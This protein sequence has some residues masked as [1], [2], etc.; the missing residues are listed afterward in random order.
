MKKNILVIMLL[1]ASCTQGGRIEKFSRSLGQVDYIKPLSCS[2]QVYWSFRDSV[3]GV[4][5][6]REEFGVCVYEYEIKTIERGTFILKEFDMKNLE[7]NLFFYYDGADFYII[8]ES[9]TK[10]DYNTTM[11]KLFG[12]R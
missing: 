4:D 1:L 5:Y 2:N 10:L 7:E 12:V 8:S 6:L 3:G 11:K 9:G